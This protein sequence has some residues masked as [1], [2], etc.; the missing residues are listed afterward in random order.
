MSIFKSGLLLPVVVGML[1]LAAVPA[2]HADYVFSGS[3]NSGTL[4]SGSEPWVFNNDGGAAS[5]G[6]L[7]NWGSPG[8]GA[9]T[10][11]YSRPDSVYGMSITFTGGGTINAPSIAI[12]NTSAC[13]GSTTGGT[14]FCTIGSSNDVWEAFLTGPDTIEFRAQDASFFLTQGQSYFVNIFFDGMAATSFTG[15]WLTSFSPDPTGVPEPGSVALFGAGL[16]GLG[17]LLRRRKRC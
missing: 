9:G 10:A 5:T 17:L 12:G 8:V 1:A 13:A 4:N 2:A 3:G 15:R 7:D 14:T 16:L 6:Y 11:S